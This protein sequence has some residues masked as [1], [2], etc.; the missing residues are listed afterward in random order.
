IAEVDGCATV[1]RP[2]AHSRYLLSGYRRGVHDPLSVRRRCWGIHHRIVRDLAGW[3]SLGSYAEL[4]ILLSFRRAEDDFIQS[5]EHRSGSFPGNQLL[6]G[7]R[8]VQ[9][10]EPDSG[11]AIGFDGAVRYTPAICGD[12]VSVNGNPR[13]ND[14]RLTRLQIS[15]PKLSR[16]EPSRSSLAHE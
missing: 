10:G 9:G 14:I 4:V 8:P 6:G 5:G 13:K 11:G 3:T 15:L 7:E 2:G 16:E 12:V 1:Q